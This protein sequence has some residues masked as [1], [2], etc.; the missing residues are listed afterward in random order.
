MASERLREAMGGNPILPA[1][2]EWLGDRLINVYGESPNMDFVQ[3]C[4]RRADSIRS[5]LAASPQA[6]ACPACHGMGT[7][8]AQDDIPHPVRDELGVDFKCTKCNGARTA[9][10]ANPEDSCECNPRCALGCVPTCPVCKPQPEGLAQGERE[11]IADFICDESYGIATD[12]TWQAKTR[13]KDW[14][15]RIRAGEFGKKGER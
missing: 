7:R 4:Y 15:A 2:L 10:Q 5:A 8:A 9:P 14:A 12:T 13:A 1:F 6:G 3:A 11:A